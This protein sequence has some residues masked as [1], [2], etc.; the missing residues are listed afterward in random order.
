MR[1]TDEGKAYPPVAGTVPHA[2]W[3]GAGYPDYPWIFATDAEYTA[4]AAVTV[5]QFGA[6][7]DHARVLRDVSEIVNGDS[8][9]VAHEIVGD[10]SVYYGATV[11]AG[12]HRRDGEVPE[13]RRALWRW[14]GDDAF[15]DD[16]YP[17]ASAT[18]TT[19]SSSSTPTAT[20]G[21]RASATSSAPGWARRSS[22]TPST[23]SADCSIS[24]T[25]RRPR[26]TLR[27][28]VG[29]PARARPGAAGSRTPG[30]SAAPTPV[31]R[32]ARRPGQREDVPEAL[33]RRDA[34]GGRAH[35]RRQGRPGLA[36]LAH[37]TAALAGREGDCYSGTGPYN[38][39]LFHTACGGGADRKG[40]RTIFGSNTA[41]QA[42]GEGNY[43]RLAQQKRY[44]D[45]EVE[46]MFGEP[47]GDGRDAGRAARRLA[48]DLPVARLRRGRRDANVERCTRCRSM[49]MQA[50]NQYG[51]MWPVVHQQLGVRPDLG[52]GRLTVVP[53][54]PSSAPIAGRTS[55]SATAALDQVNVR[56]D[57]RRYGTSVKASHV[58]ANRL[59]IGQTLPRGAS[60]RSVTLDGQRHSWHAADDQPRARG[61]R[62]DA[63]RVGTRW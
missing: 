51:T 38:H 29:A 31:R 22:T 41:I 30:G 12:Q 47:G 25:W 40:E 26:A 21:P 45:A 24:P 6:I 13:P 48:G 5:G 43:G 20:A 59:V 16:L 15:R 27:P 58:P 49:V 2:R 19:S 33:D 36:S 54:L 60:I 44:T 1:F 10:G 34:D 46:P 52:R 37:G 11:D 61:H 56:R 55:S 14:T 57:G 7:K 42:V 28:R 9:K 39:G 18:C 50:W 4:F 17:F 62:R 53:Q 32:L 63:T 35:P 3:I 23:R 8:G